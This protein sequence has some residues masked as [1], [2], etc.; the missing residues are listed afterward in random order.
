MPARQEYPHLTDAHWATLEKM[1]S[2]LG[3]QAFAGFP[4]LPEG[5]QRARIER[6]AKY[7]SSLIAHLTAVATEGASASVLGAVQGQLGAQAAPPPPPLVQGPSGGRL[8]R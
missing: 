7:E 2:V 4:S 5:E 8:D 6:F 1:L 3:E